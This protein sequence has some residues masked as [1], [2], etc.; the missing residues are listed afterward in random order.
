[1]FTRKIFHFACLANVLCLMICQ[2]LGSSFEKFDNIRKSESLTDREKVKQYHILVESLSPEGFLE[3]GRTLCEEIQPKYERA[4]MTERAGIEF[5][6]L[7]ILS[8]YIEKGGPLPDESYLRREFLN[9]NSP[10]LWRNY[11]MGMLKRS[12]I[13]EDRKTIKVIPP[14]QL[15]SVVSLMEAVL[16]DNTEPEDIRVSAC[17]TIFDLLHTQLGVWSGRPTGKNEVAI[18]RGLAHQHVEQLGR[19]VNEPSNGEWLVETSISSLGKYAKDGLVSKEVVGFRLKE[20]IKNRSKL[21]PNAQLTLVRT[22]AI[23]LSDESVQQELAVMRDEFQD[24]ILKME[25]EDLLKRLGIQNKAKHRE[26]A[27]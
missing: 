4:S 13:D 10:H 23:D 11:L 20:L 14:E 5:T 1:M 21:P 24:P 6:L 9:K 25:A 22:L 19:I 17:L 26:S 15:Q 2:A 8:P 27:D 7:T 12:Y 16:S 3:L 18:I